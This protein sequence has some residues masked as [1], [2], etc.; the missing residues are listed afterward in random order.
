M[1]SVTFEKVGHEDLHGAFRIVCRMHRCCP[2]DSRTVVYLH[3]A[4][5]LDLCDKNI[6]GP[7]ADNPHSAVYFHVFLHGPSVNG[8]F[9]DLIR[10]TGLMSSQAREKRTSTAFFDLNFSSACSFPDEYADTLLPS[11]TLPYGT[12]FSYS[13]LHSRLIHILSDFYPLRQRSFTPILTPSE[14]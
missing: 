2:W 8:S 3:H 6:E 7:K 4:V 12:Y 11:F 10:E 9:G 14:C 5:I 1:D 13:G